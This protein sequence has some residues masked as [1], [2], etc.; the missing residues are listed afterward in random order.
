MSSVSQST[1]I[2]SIYKQKDFFC[3]YAMTS[4][5]FFNNYIKI[6]GL[7]DKLN[8]SQDKLKMHIIINI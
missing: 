8:K 4:F 3:A 5:F 1:N 2:I 6:T 7:Q